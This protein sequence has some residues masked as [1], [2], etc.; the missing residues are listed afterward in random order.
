MIYD[1]MPIIDYFRYVKEDMIAGAMDAKTSPDG[2]YYF[3]LYKWSWAWAVL[4]GSY[5]ITVV[6]IESLLVWHEKTL[7]EQHISVE[8]FEFT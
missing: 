5:Y 4:T 2:T 1:D 7:D 3:Y 8:D 6:P